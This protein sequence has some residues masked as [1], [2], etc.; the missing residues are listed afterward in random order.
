MGIYSCGRV[1]P[2][3]QEIP[4]VKAGEQPPRTTGANKPA[5]MLSTAQDWQL[6][7]GPGEPAEVPMTY[8]HNIPKAR[9][10]PGL[11]GNQEHCLVGAYSAAGGLSG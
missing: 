9:H 2:T 11:G 4:F 1:H 7:Y 8:H 3:A 6:F 5:G 10:P